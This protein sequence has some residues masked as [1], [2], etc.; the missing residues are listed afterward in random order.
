MEDEVE[1]VVSTGLFEESSMSWIMFDISLKEWK[2]DKRLKW[3]GK[4]KE[5]EKYEYQQRIQKTRIIMKII[6]GIDK[7][8]VKYIE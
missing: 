3:N 8:E 6:K 5:N 4:W 1:G 2:I 7:L